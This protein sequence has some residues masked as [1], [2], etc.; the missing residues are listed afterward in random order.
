MT[1]KWT[2]GERRQRKHDVNVRDGNIYVTLTERD[3]TLDSDQYN[4]KKQE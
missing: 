3:G 1:A 2:A 4:G